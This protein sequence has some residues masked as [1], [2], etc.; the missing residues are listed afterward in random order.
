MGQ[1]S[2]LSTVSLI[3]FQ[4]TVASLSVA[5]HALREEPYERLPCLAGT[6]QVAQSQMES[7]R[8]EAIAYRQLYDAA[9]EVLALE[10]N[11]VNADG[12]EPYDP[13][14]N[15]GQFDFRVV[16]LAKILECG[17]D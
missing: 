1:E 15:P 5:E 13:I 7:L 17:G 10:C 8:Q 14:A 6:M 4:M 2:R 11:R 3:D 12:G 9:K 16:K